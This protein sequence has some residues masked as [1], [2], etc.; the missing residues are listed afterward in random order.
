[1]KIDSTHTD[2]KPF[3]EIDIE[4][5]FLRSQNGETILE[6]LERA[7]VEANYNCREGFCGVCRTKLLSGSVEYKVEPLAFI[8][9]DEILT[10]CS[11]PTSDI[12]LKKAF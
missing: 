11:T 2:T 7:K 6:T 8:D 5:K 1:V 10:C 3:N 9:D 4:D 12:K